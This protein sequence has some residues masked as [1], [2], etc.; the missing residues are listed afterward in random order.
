MKNL[1]L[2]ALSILL[3]AL[4]CSKDRGIFL[5]NS[6]IK[7][8][9]FTEAP[10]EKLKEAATPPEKK[11]IASDDDL[12]I[13]GKQGT[14]L[15]LEPEDLLL[16]DGTRA[17]YPI[18]VE[19]LEVYKPKDMI[20]N[21]ISTLSFRRMLSTA[22]QVNITASKDGK[23][24]TLSKNNSTSINFPATSKVDHEMALFY[25]VEENGSLNNWVGADTTT[26][27]PPLLPSRDGYSAFPSQLGWINVDKF[28]NSVEPITAITF[29]SEYPTIDK[30]E[31]YLYF[32]DL[33]SVMR[34]YGDK[35]GLVPIGSKV[36]LIAI[37]I[38]DKDEWYSF[39]LETTVQD[40]QKID[41]KLAPTT[42]ED[43]MKYLDTL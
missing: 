24:L 43:L 40:K 12:P 3:F 32:P 18:Q 35:S 11:T 9:K 5:K 14:E 36:K 10:G 16:P 4:A 22:G 13:V 28:I 20:L 17:T 37:S 34:I 27:T 25:G 42:K 2:L 21:R 33:K 30:I 19:I 29:Q 26:K 41:I 15:W 8:K 7:E 38:T 31:I 6:G 39:S 23:P 1:L